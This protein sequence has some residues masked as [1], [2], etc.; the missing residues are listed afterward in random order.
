MDYGPCSTRRSALAQG[1]FTLIEVIIVIAI[2]AILVAVGVPSMREMIA[3]QKVRGSANDLLFDLSFARAEAIKRNANVVLVP[4]GAAWAGGWSVQ[5]GGT[6][7]REQPA[8]NGVASGAAANLTFGP[9]GR[10]TATP[11]NPFTTF[12]SSSGVVSMRCI[13][14]SP[15]GRAAVRTD[16]DHDGDCTNG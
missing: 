11:A 8:I 14:I 9:D 13:T 3:N 6:K 15:S 7:I 4:T 2:A 1:G 5:F 12:S 10:P 16:R